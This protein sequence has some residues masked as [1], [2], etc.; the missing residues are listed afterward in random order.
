ML[1]PACSD[2]E[3][4]EGPNWPGDAV[5]VPVVYD[6]E[7]EMPKMFSSSV[8]SKSSEY[9]LGSW[10]ETDAMAAVWSDTRSSAQTRVQ[11]RRARY[12]RV[13]VEEKAQDYL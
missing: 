10:P 1:G 12:E 6:G 3:G 11:R 5:P 9:S 7:G 13:V 2:G 4:S 8:V